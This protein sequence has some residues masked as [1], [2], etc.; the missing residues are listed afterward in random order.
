MG[1]ETIVWIVPDDASQADIA[2]ADLRK[3]GYTVV[4]QSLAAASRLAAD[5]RVLPTASLADEAT[6][7]LACAADR[8]PTLVLAHDEAAE[9]VAL[10]VCD[11]RDEVVR[12]PQAPQHVAA[13]LERLIRRERDSAW[14]HRDAVTGLLNR[15]AFGLRLRKVLEEMLPGEVRGLVR[16]DLDRFRLLND[17]FGHAVGDQLLRSAA[18]LLAAGASPEDSIGRVG[19]DEFVLLLSRY[20]LQT[21]VNDA[22][23]LLKRLSVPIEVPSAGRSVVLTASAGMTVLRPHFTESEVMRQADA[24]M[25]E[26]KGAG[27]NRLMC[28]ETAAGGYVAPDIDADLDRFNE[29]TKV[30]SDRLARIVGDMGRR[31]VEGAR[32]QALQ[33][34]LTGAHNRRY[35]DERLAREV[36]QAHRS[37]RPLALALLDIDDFHG[38]NANFGWPSGDG[39]LRE[40]AALAGGNVRLVDWLARYGGEEFCVVLPDTTAE[41]AVSVMERI[42]AAV[43][44][45]R[46]E[47][48][49]GRPVSVTVSV[50]VA[51]TAPGDDSPVALVDRAGR[52][53]L[54]AKAA[55]KNRVVL[56]DAAA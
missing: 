25:Y 47:A 45:H 24:A 5:L 18:E 39:V 54:R 42:R 30:F 2:A 23:A 4:E 32:R 9:A 56:G 22:H 43:G 27:R 41:A 12:L 44:G 53:C 51:M 29:V 52:A 38:I 48:T 35:F 8:R 15:R 17:E 28:F 55:G 46:F 49:D 3:A 20:D 36:S 14:L 33:D 7:R 11:L 31:L 1:P 19:G 40:F 50:G 13:R 34:A 16:L 6:L 26:A 21:L 10:E 37:G